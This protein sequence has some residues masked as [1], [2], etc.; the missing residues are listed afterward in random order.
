MFFDNEEQVK[1][2]N[3]RIN[4]ENINEMALYGA[5]ENST[6]FFETKEFERLL[7]DFIRSKHQYIYNFNLP[8]RTT[9][10]IR[11]QANKALIMQTEDIDR[12]VLYVDGNMRL[13][14]DF[15]GEFGV[16]LDDSNSDEFI[17]YIKKHAKKKEVT[18][19]PIKWSENNH[20]NGS[21]VV[22]QVFSGD[23][24]AIIKK[25]PVI[26]TGIEM[27]NQT[28]DLG[29]SVLVHEMTHALVNRH[30]GIIENRLHRELLSIYMELVAAYELDKSGKF[31]E[32][33][34][35]DRIQE[36]KNEIMSLHQNAY[37]GYIM[38][39]GAK[40]IDSSLYAFALFEQDR[41]ASDTARKA[42]RKEINKTFS[43]DR[44]LE[45]TL[46]K[47]DITEEEGSHIIRGHIK[48]LMK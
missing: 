44:T 22:M 48:T 43:G 37:N 28:D 35:I 14:Q 1:R 45:D 12:K 10:I 34:T 42:L 2:T 26:S 41:S 15:E 8:S 24:I 4:K 11:E 6:D 23:K 47:L 30:K 40:Y 33:A 25:L 7:I 21:S 9:K 29:S 39:A 36:I 19:L 32:I 16:K 46:A 27:L 31:L 17:K 20:R 18:A 38:D 13:V 5:T 3:E